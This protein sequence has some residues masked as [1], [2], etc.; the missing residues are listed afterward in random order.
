MTAWQYSGQDTDSATGTRSVIYLLPLAVLMIAG[1][2][3][4]GAGSGVRSVSDLAFM[5]D[6]TQLIIRGGSYALALV[7]FLGDFS[8]NIR[9]FT[10]KS[11]FL[12]FSF[13]ILMTAYWSAY[14]VKVVV[15]WGHQ[16]GIALTVMMACRYFML[17]KS[18][19]FRFFSYV[20]GVTLLIS[21]VAIAAFPSYGVGQD[22]RWQGI[23]GNAN[24]LGMICIISIWSNLA[25]I[26]TREKTHSCL[27]NKL[28]LALSIAVLIGTN[29]MT[30]MVVSLFIV[31]A[32]PFLVSIE[33][34]NDLVRKFKI[35]MVLYS[36]VLMIAIANVKLPEMLSLEGIT[37]AVGRS[38]DFS[39]RVGVWEE[40]MKVFYMHP[41][42]G[43]SF[44][45]NMSVLSSVNSF[46]IGQF[47]NGYIDVL[48]R[49]G[50]IGFSF[51]L[52]VLGRIFILINE[53]KKNDYRHA[54]IFHVLLLAV[55]LHNISETSFVRSA[56]IL[57]MMVLFSYYYLDAQ[58]NRMPD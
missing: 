18:A 14:P 7:L 17:N 4:L 41:I 40:A 20:T 36:V 24:T 38:A 51:V 53:N 47:H 21:V 58:L 49:G 11:L 33:K 45:S 22:G 27:V 12:F 15:N 1:G 5:N 39:G 42:L 50:V 16:V 52:L 25:C 10:G 23:A 56:H 8:R 29:S 2:I 31:F 13:Y 55:L 30:S 9:W 48:V 34:N 6:P 3:N 54:V 35:V 44:D 37:G 43:W 57:W 19:T 26:L 32:M 28:M 46:R